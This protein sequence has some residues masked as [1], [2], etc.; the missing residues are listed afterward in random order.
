V[1][2]L[3]LIISPAVIGHSY[4]PAE[5]DCPDA[6]ALI[7]RFSWS[8]AFVRRRSTRSGSPRDRWPGA[9]SALSK[10]LLRRENRA[11][12]AA[13]CN[14]LFRDDLSWREIRLHCGASIAARS[15]AGRGLRRW[16][17]VPGPGAASDAQFTVVAEFIN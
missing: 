9:S 13:I 17:S 15:K 5:F 1:L 3:L 14:G 11:C 6:V 4:S 12:S 10:R 7:N 16:R 8:F 2:K